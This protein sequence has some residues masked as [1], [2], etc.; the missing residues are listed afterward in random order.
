MR[1]KEFIAVV[2]QKAGLDESDAEKAVNASIAAITEA[3]VKGDY[4]QLVGFGTFEVREK[5]DSVS[6]NPHKPGEKIDVPA[7]NYPVFKASAN[8]KA[9]VK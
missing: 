8:L 3:L 7:H 1:K 6:P 5:K 9:A 4:V 2:A